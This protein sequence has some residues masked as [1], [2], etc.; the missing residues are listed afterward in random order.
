[1][2]AGNDDSERTVTGPVARD[3]AAS[4]F[5][6]SSSM[7]VHT[8]PEGTRIRD[9]KIT[10]LIGEGGFGIV[11]LAFDVSLQRRVAIKE[12]LPSSMASRANASMAV[13]VKS[14]RHQE[15]FALGL[16]SFLNEARLLARF[17]HPS[18]VK[19]YRFWEENNTAYMVMPYYEG[20][21]L[22]KVLADLGHAPDEAALRTWLRPLLDA[23]AVMHAA[24]C[25]HRDI[26]PDN[27]LLTAS[28]PL[29][30]DFGAARR[31]IGDMTHALTVVLKPGFAP[32]E[33]YGE[34]SA[35][36]QGAW[37]DLYALASVVYAAVTGHAPVSSVERLMDDRL[38]PLSELAAGRYSEP[39]LTA[40]DAALA[41]RPADRPQT[42]AAFRALLDGREA[43]VE[44]SL[45]FASTFAAS[46][47][48]ALPEATLPPGRINAP[49]IRLDSVPPGPGIAAEGAARPGR[50][51]VYALFGAVGLLGLA[52]AGYYF[53]GER[54]T[55]PVAEP[56]VE[57]AAPA[58][59]VAATAPPPATL[60]TPAP[61]PVPAPVVVAAPAPVIETPAPPPASATTAPMVS[62]AASKP[63][64]EPRIVEPRVAEPRPVAA[65]PAPK[66]APTNTAV[67]KARCSDILQKASLEP[68]TASEAE[69]LK[70]ECR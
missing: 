41:L 11:Y 63:K 40:I 70:K 60:P 46:L 56:S 43:Q 47:D 16:K 28:G 14:A 53:G 21:T 69:F 35:M 15:T 48:S 44:P 55:K 45:G 49:D 66:P 25:F 65:E 7:S 67:N 24:H 57:A 8:L 27:I 33:Q 32:I 38:R 19:V 54:D 68:L 62:A 20:P 10:G 61:A 3:G 30:L 39:F 52:A 12:Y 22:K 31:V 42:V 2:S 26:A 34:S 13:V 9:Y 51:R 58:A 59:S 64:R 4:E 5:A 36:T 17:D 50:G 29:L 37:T 1:M 18:L 23:L 6:P